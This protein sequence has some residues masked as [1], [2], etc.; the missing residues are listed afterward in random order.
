MLRELIAKVNRAMSERMVAPRRKHSAP[1]KLWFDADLNSE[2]AQEAARAACIIGETIDF[3]R[4]GISFLVPS[5]RTKEKYLVGQ[6]RNINVEIDLPTG[7]VFLRV[8]GKRYK[9][10]GSHSSTEKFLVGAQISSLSGADLD[11]FESFLRDGHR[12]AKGTA[13]GLDRSHGGA[14]SP[15]PQ[16]RR[17]SLE[18]RLHARLAGAFRSRPLPLISVPMS[19]RV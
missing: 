7:K 1:I 18:R 9:K 4:T 3:S 2:R 12:T 13:H 11:N 19:R 16:A 15:A 6:E 10:V 14:F 17:H 5:I 8:L